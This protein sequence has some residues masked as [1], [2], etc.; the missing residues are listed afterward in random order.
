[1]VT[2]KD[3][4]WINY[5]KAISIIGVFLAHSAVFYSI[6]IGCVNVFINPFYV[7]A[8]FFISGYL[9]FRKQLSVKLIQED[10]KQFLLGGGNLL[11]NNIFF[12]LMIPTLI[13]STIE[14]FPSHILR[15]HDFDLGTFMAINKEKKYLVLFF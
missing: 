12:R 10:Y 13:F 1:M 4:F 3:I 2:K 5:V 7:N 11:I 14:F 9:L 6:S 15:G 8:F